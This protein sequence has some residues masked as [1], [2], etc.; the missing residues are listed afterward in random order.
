[1]A[2]VDFPHTYPT[3]LNS[4]HQVHVLRAKHG[5]VVGRVVVVVGTSSR[6]IRRLSIVE[7]S[8]SRI[9]SGPISSIDR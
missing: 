5:P 1:M 3:V 2:V 4:H 7:Q 9:V 8:C 6:R